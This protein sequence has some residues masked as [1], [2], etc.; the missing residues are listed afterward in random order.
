VGDKSVALREICG[1]YGITL[2]E[3]LY[4]GDD[5]ND[6]T[7]FEVAGV[8]VAVGD[9]CE[10]LKRAAHYVTLAPGGKGAVREVIDLLLKA[11]GYDLVALWKTGNDRPVGQQ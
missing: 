7:A 9:A 3:I 1:E 2:A 11:K 6:Y 4:I 8:A 5:L 10:E